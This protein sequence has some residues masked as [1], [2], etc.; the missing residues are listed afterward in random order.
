MST[1]EDAYEQI[2]DLTKLPR[3]VD[4]IELIEEIISEPV[5]VATSTVIPI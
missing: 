1:S 5:S 4:I 3:E 2:Y